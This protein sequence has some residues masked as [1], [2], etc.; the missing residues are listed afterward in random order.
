[1]NANGRVVGQFRVHR[2]SAGVVTGHAG[3]FAHRCAAQRAV[4]AEQGYGFQNG[5][6]PGSVGPGDNN[7]SRPARF[8]AGKRVITKISQSYRVDHL[9]T[10]LPKKTA[11]FNENSKTGKDQFFC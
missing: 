9:G 7:I 11:P 2:K 5:G 3:D 1:M 4:S 6:F 10:F 8:N